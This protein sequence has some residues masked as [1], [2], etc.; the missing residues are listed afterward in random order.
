[1]RGPDLMW[2]GDIK[3]FHVPPGKFEGIFGGSPCKAHTSLRHIIKH[4]GHKLAENLIPEFERCVF[5]GQPEF[6]LHENTKDAPVP[7]VEGY[8]IHSFLL[9]NRWLGEEQN[10]VRRFSFG[11]K[12]T[13]IDL[14]QYI[15][16]VALENP[17]WEYAVTAMGYKCVPVKLLKGGKTRTSLPKTGIKRS[18][19]ECLRLQGLPEDFFKH[20]AFKVAKQREMVGNGVPLPMGKVIV[21]AIKK[22]LES[23]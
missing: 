10:R 4:N 12:S 23:K 7:V 18:L 8:K 13:I 1:M 15:Q 5:E 9:N 22:Y 11:T 20:N 16:P 19:K 21:G 3:T 2:S 17:V 14:S 6:F